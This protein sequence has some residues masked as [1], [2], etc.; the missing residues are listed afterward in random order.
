MKPR[1]ALNE[2]DVQDVP[3]DVKSQLNLILVETVDEVLA[4]AFEPPPAHALRRKKLRSERARAAK[5]SRS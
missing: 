5:K 1:T 3:A 4:A 2:K